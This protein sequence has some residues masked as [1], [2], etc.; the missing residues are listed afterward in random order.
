MCHTLSISDTLQYSTDNQEII[1]KGLRNILKLKTD[2]RSKELSYK[3]ILKKMMTQGQLKHIK[4]DPTIHNKFC[5][6]CGEDRHFGNPMHY[7][8]LCLPAKIITE[9][10][11]KQVE[12]LCNYPHI[13]KGKKIRDPDNRAPMDK[14]PT[15]L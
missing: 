9:A 10:A 3:I 13:I 14:Q 6:T 2:K 12:K 8:L 4:K 5:L 1:A 11:A 7:Y 15:D